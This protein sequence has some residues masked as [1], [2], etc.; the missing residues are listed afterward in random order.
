MWKPGAAC[1]APLSSLLLEVSDCSQMPSITTESFAWVQLAAR[2]ETV[3]AL[4]M[5][6]VVMKKS[7][8]GRAFGALAKRAEPELQRVA[9]AAT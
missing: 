7:G 9:D 3:R 2:M 1:P 8:L 6:A 4:E 5:P